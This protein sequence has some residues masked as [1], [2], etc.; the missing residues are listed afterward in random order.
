MVLFVRELIENVPGIS[1]A[2]YLYPPPQSGKPYQEAQVVRL[3]TSLDIAF[4]VM[5]FAKID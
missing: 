4:G 3:S 1:S 5:L 2:K